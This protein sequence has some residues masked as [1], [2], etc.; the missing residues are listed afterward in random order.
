MAVSKIVRRRARSSPVKPARASVSLRPCEAKAP[1]PTAMAAS[2]APM[3]IQRREREDII[4]YR[5][6]NRFHVAEFVR[7]PLRQI[8][9]LTNS[10]TPHKRGQAKR[11][12]AH[13]ASKTTQ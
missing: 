10:A 4:A 12:R 6:R 9:I 1:R 3:A 13:F 2:S 5:Y 8:G 11:G 7:I